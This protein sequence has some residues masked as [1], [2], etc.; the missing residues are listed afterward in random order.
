LNG[1]VVIYI[2]ISDPGR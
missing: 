1:G 2:L